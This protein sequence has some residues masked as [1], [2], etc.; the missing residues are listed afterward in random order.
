MNKE[1]ASERK[2]FTKLNEEVKTR[3]LELSALKKEL[4]EKE[5]EGKNM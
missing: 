1:V 3:Q 2:R 5:W 4:S